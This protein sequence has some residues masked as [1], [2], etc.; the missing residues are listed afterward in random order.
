MQPI[1]CLAAAVAYLAVLAAPSAAGLPGLPLPVQQEGAVYRV[2]HWVLA[3][4][5]VREINS[6]LN[7]W[8][9]NNW[10]F[11]SGKGSWDWP[12]ETA[13]VTGGAGGIGAIVVQRLLSHGVTVAVLDV[14]PLS[15]IFTPEERKRIKLYHCDVSSP[16]AVHKAAEA[17]RSDHASPSI[18][19]NNAG[20]GRGNTILETPPE[21]LQRVM[22]INLLSQWYTIQEFLPDMLKKRKGHIMSTASMSAFVAMAGQADYAATKA[23]LMALHESLTAEL[24]HLYKCPEIKTTV[25]FPTW[26]RTALTAPLEKGIRSSGAAMVDPKDVAELM[27][28]QILA[29]KGGRLIWDPIGVV[30]AIRALPIWAQ[31]LIHDHLAQV[32][33]GNEITGIAK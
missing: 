8:A 18:L 7:A 12:Q 24:K 4:W 22:G 19:I 25:V 3:L 1:R 16:D 30:P 13:V 29:A 11:R 23:G 31:A 15:D 26:T 2:L 14:Q 9:E 5:L 28:S 32:A 33:I 6:L 21:R 17:L 27:V 20:I 10:I